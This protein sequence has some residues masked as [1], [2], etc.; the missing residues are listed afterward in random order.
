MPCWVMFSV[1]CTEMG[2]SDT[3]PKKCVSFK[4]QNFEKVKTKNKRIMKLTQDQISEFIA[5]MTRSPKG[6]Q[7]LFSMIMN[8]LM[9]EDC[10]ISFFRSK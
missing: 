8:A 1:C 6:L 5:E 9:K 3:V 7:E 2:E 4:I 10:A